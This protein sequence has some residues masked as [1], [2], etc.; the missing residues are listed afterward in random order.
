MPARS[1]LQDE[2]A[3]NAAAG[4]ENDDA[5]RHLS[6][7]SATGPIAQSAEGSCLVVRKA[8]PELR[9]AGRRSVRPADG[10]RFD[11]TRRGTF[12]TS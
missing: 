12:L 9:E 1:G 11:R 8:R 5:D 6:Q 10:S 4:S 3:A 2:F 7:M